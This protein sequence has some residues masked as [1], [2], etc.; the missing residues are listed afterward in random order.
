MEDIISLILTITGFI[1]CRKKSGSGEPIYKYGSWFFLL[2][3][4]SFILSLIPHLIIWFGF[5]FLHKTLD[6]SNA[7]VATIISLVSLSELIVLW[8]AIVFLIFGFY[9]RQAAEQNKE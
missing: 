5:D 9:R 8:G 3:G 4:V 2:L 7:Q 1:I 6:L